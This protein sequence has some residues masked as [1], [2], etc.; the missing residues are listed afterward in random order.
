MLL[1]IAATSCYRASYWQSTHEYRGDPADEAERQ[2]GSTPE[3]TFDE[4]TLRLTVT[5]IGTCRPALVGQHLAEHQRGRARLRHDMLLKG[6]GAL[7]VAAGLLGTAVGAADTSDTTTIGTPRTPIFSSGT[8]DALIVGG[9]GA[10]VVGTVDLVFSFTHESKDV[11]RWAPVPGEPSYVF[12]S[13]RTTR[14]KA[15]PAPVE[16]VSAH[17]EVQ[18]ANVSG[19]LAWDVETDAAGVAAIELDRIRAAAGYC[20]AATVRV[21]DGDLRWTAHVRG[22]RIPIDQIADEPARNAASVCHFTA[23][24][25]CLARAQAVP[26]GDTDACTDEC[27]ARVD[28]KRCTVGV[29]GCLREATEDDDR[30]LCQN[31]LAACLDEEGV[32]R[33]AL[34]ACAATCRGIAAD[35][36]CQ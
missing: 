23:R 10:L 11:E 3:A 35:T 12:T 7:L 17:V 33:A 21:S 22:E 18:F 1:A 15:P 16:G 27:A 36:E 25:Q 2:V 4:D 29:R 9:L 26:G 19:R 24:Q 8:R 20:G 6:G 34:D 30:Q 31:E 28:A 5:S 14:C 32:D 13:E